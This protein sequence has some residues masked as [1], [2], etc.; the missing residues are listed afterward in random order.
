[1]SH[2]KRNL[3]VL[4]SAQFLTMVGFSLY[5]SFIPYYM[6]EISGISDA[7]AMRWAA[8]FQTGGAISMMIAA[9]IWGTLADRYGRK[10]MLV[11][12]T[13]AG[14]IMA[15][16]MGLAQ[17][18]GQILVLRVIQGGFSG[19]AAA[20]MTLAATTT[21]EA[22]LG[23]AL[24]LMQMI[25]FVSHAVGPFIGGILADA[26]SYRA[27]FPIASGMMV[28]SLISVVLAV[29]ENREAIA[30]RK[31]RERVR[32]GRF[33]FTSVVGM[34]SLL[35]IGALAGTSLAASTLSPVLAMYIKSLA[36]TSDRLATLAGALTSVSSV[37]ASLAALGIGYFGDRFG[38]K[39]A[40]VACCLGV[41]AV[42]IP[43]AFVTTALQLAILRGIHGMF[44]GGI[45]PTANAL[46][47]Q[48]TAPERRGSVLGLS[49]GAQSG[50]RA[51]GPSLGA[52]AAASWG[53]GSTFLL[54]GGV[55]LLLSGLIAWF[56]R[57]APH[58]AA[59]PAPEAGP[60]A[61]LAEPSRPAAG[62]SG[63][64]VPSSP[65]SRQDR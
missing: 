60:S 10:M 28:V 9:P 50:G 29:R 1:M 46:L 5:M 19:T 11:R 15:F 24:G 65:P 49:S 8:Y 45:M 36:P 41:A 4:A 16:L 23:R 58:Q 47:T 59:T 26:L 2:W 44:V 14:S 56:V 63:W 30:G 57:V 51:V 55:F 61:P 43:Q 20:A 64:P 21:P 40:L 53:M 13:A 3:A 48:S 42:A 7:E 17:S 33:R 32:T 12:A 35:L 27:V 38:Q 25:S 54:N 34:D 37:T 18:P 62:R 31:P 6:Q 52:A 22:S 39:R